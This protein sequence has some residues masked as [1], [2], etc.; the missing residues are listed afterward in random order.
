MAGITDIVTN[1]GEDF[2]DELT[3]AIVYDE[4]SKVFKDIKNTL[5]LD[6]D[7]SKVDEALEGALTT[8]Q[9]GL[10][11][12]VIITVTEYAIAKSVMLLGGLFAYIKGR[13]IIKSM[14]DAF[15]NNPILK[16]NPV[17][18][19]ASSVVSKTSDILIANQTETLA[20]A[21][22]V[23]S[24][25]NNIVSAVGK[26]RQNQILLQQNK[27]NRIDNAKKNIYS[28]RNNS[29]SK[30]MELFIHKF[31]TATWKDTLKDKK[32][33]FDCTGQD[34]KIISFNK[35]F[36]GKI[37]SY[38]N[39]ATTATGQIYSNAK[40]TLDLITQVGAKL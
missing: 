27:L 36:V 21:N 9:Y 16:R 30:N 17:G 39:I 5:G 22:M 20:L 10:M 19:V 37:N 32:L 6:P 2:I 38:A 28:V 1:S 11:N 3:S 12:L 29:R 8:L 4:G 18:F 7:S 14:I 40:A 34:E 23:N 25:G 24:S 35:D 15:S 33:Y 26:E 31:N 13:R